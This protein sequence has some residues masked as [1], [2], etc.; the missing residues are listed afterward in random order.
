MTAILNL[1]IGGKTVSLTAWHMAEVDSAQ[2]KSYR[3]N[4]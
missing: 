3:T 2:K 4:K 1:T